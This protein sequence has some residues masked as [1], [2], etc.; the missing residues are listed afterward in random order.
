M[1]APP[2]GPVEVTGMLEASEAA[3]S[4]IGADGTVQEIATPLLVNVW[5]APMYAGYVAETS[6][7]PGLRP[8]PAAV[9]EFS[10][11]L[12]L[13]N[14][15]YA[16]QWILFGGFFLY[17]WWRS[18]RTRYLD[19]RADAHDRLVSRLAASGEDTGTPT[20]HDS[21]QTAPSGAEEDTRADDTTAR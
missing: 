8:M 13:Q 17:L 10:R 12:N 4:G 21:M 9:S 5:G 16:A 3:Q 15:G 1:P 11:G 20:T 18:V 6:P 19:E 7:S 2:A 14:L